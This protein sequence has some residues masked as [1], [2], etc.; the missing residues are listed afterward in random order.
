[1]LGLKKCT[2][3]ADTVKMENVTS[4]LLVFVCMFP[5]LQA[6]SNPGIDGKS[7]SLYL[8]IG[9]MFSRVKEAFTQLNFGRFSENLCCVLLRLKYHA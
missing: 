8:I 1:M 5:L 4:F 6:V 9:L 2:A 7:N 3:A